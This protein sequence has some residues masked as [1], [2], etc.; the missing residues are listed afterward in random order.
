MNNI[1][2]A[3]DKCKHDINIEG[4]NECKYDEHEWQELW[5]NHVPYTMCCK[6]GKDEE[7]M[8]K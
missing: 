3:C 4:I 6:C 8:W 2:R 7:Y 1:Y 5:I